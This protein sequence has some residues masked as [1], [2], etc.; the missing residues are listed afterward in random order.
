MR[1]NDAPFATLLRVLRTLCH[2]YGPSKNVITRLGGDEYSSAG[3]ISIAFVCNGR[4]EWNGVFNSGYEVTRHVRIKRNDSF[5]FSFL[6][7]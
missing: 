7:G 2:A 5:C 1:M 3:M 6:S 4:V